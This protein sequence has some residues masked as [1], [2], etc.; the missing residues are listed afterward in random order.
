[1]RACVV[2]STWAV[3]GRTGADFTR[4]G[5]VASSGRF[6]TTPQPSMPPCHA[7]PVRAVCVCGVQRLKKS[8]GQLQTTAALSLPRLACV[9]TPQ[10]FTKAGFTDVKIKHIGPTWYRGVRRHGLIMGCSVSGTKPKVGGQWSLA[11]KLKG[12]S[13]LIVGCS[14]SG[15]QP[16]VGG[17]W[18]ARG[19]REDLLGAHHG[20]LQRTWPWVMSCQWEAKGWKRTWGLVMR[21]STLGRGG[22]GLIVLGA[23]A[24]APP[25]PISPGPHPHKPPLPSPC[26]QA[27]DSPL[28]MGPKVETSGG[29]INPVS[30]LFRMLLGTLAGSYYFILPI[31]M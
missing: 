19:K 27:G 18:P 15:T 6:Q 4:S 10:W 5:D 2:L 17:L 20:L 28:Q 12:L 22:P 7:S 24:A 31:Y 9:C 29:P 16:E 3:L 13:G 30:F 21:C 26:T 14:V 8:L 23:S 11:A 25:H 1:M